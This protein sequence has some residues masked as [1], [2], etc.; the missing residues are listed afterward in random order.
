MLLIKVIALN[1]SNISIFIQSYYAQGYVVKCPECSKQFKFKNIPIEN[2]QMNKWSTSFFCPRCRVLLKPNKVFEV[3]NIS[4]LSMVTL[5]IFSLLLK[6]WLTIE[7]SFSISLA[8]IITG[9]LLY[10]FSFKYLKLIRSD[11]KR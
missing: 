3:L 1:L 8:L 7:I 10:Y 11:L 6:L 4:S 2:R 5:G 9:V